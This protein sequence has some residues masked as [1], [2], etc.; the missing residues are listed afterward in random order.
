MGFH[1]VKHSHSD[2]SVSVNHDLL[3]IKGG[4]QNVEV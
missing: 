3:K 1:G 2:E 4:F